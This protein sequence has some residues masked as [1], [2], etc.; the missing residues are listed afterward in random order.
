MRVLRVVLATAVLAIPGLGASQTHVSFQ[1]DDGGLVHADVYGRGDR[2]IV[3]A[4]GG[5]F[6]KE[7][8]GPQAARL[9][10]EGFRVVAIDFRGYGQSKGPGQVDIFS[11]PLHL[12]VFAAIRYLRAN[13]VKTVSLIGASLGGGAVARVVSE[14]PGG[15][16]D[17][18]VLLAAL[19]DTP[20][21]SLKGRKLF[22]VARDDA[23]GAGPR[24]P[25]I[26][27]QY[28]KA[29]E[30]KQLIVVDG[31]EHAQFLFFQGDQ[32]ER[33]MREIVRFLSAP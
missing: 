27:T 23:D 7:S 13:G 14:A 6:N 10:A 32:G 12:D 29:T 28:D 5:R 2:G 1:T 4:H 26:R 16:I 20:P 11:A 17:R 8:W 18:L 30:P 15:T 21:A 31:A 19:P 25:R 33:V 3:L 24:L 9:A 22:I